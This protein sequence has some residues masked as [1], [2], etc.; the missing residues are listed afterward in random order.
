MVCCHYFSE[1]CRKHEKRV[2]SCL[3]AHVSFCLFKTLLK[4]YAGNIYLFKVNNRST[5][6][7]CEICSK[8]TTIKTPETLP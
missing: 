3:V 1:I 5:E 2:K 7:G 6:K 8:L 4:T